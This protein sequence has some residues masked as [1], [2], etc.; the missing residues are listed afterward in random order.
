MEEQD[1]VYLISVHRAYTT[2]DADDIFESSWE[3]DSIPQPVYKSLTSASQHLKTLLEDHL[4]IDD[5]VSPTKDNTGHILV[6]QVVHN[7]TDP[8][9][10]SKFKCE[11]RYSV[12]YYALHD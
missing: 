9:D 10:G 2:Y 5:V 11:I 4:E 12:A 3:E 7:G 1:H 8:S 6:L